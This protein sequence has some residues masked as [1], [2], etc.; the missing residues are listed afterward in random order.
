M[1]QARLVNV[2]SGTLE[3]A[4][5]NN[6]TSTI[7]ISDFTVKT[8]D[9]GATWISNV[10]TE[11]SYVIINNTGTNDLVWRIGDGTDYWRAELAAGQYVVFPLS[12]YQEFMTTQPFTAKGLSLYSALGTKV[13]VIALF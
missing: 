3:E 6:N 4:E 2:V 1:G 13:E 9:V 11:A 7:S 12:Y 5:S 10:L 8:Y